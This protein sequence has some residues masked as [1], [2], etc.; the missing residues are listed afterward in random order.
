MV[1][2]KKIAEESGFSSATVSRLL[3]NDPT[4]SITEDTRKKILRTAVSLGYER[5]K[6]HISMDKIALLYW[7]SDKEELEDVYFR[8]MRLSIK[9]YAQLNNMDV[10][11]IKHH[12]GIEKVPKDISGFIAIGAFSTKE[13]ADLSEICPNGV[14]LDTNPDPDFF[15]SVQ[16]DTNR[17]TRKAIDYFISNNHKKIGFIGGTYLNPDTRKSEMDSREIV[18]RKYLEEKK[19][20]NEK[21]IFGEKH[22]SVKDGYEIANHLI[23]SLKKD[24][25]T[26]IFIASDPIAVGALQAFNEH[27]IPIPEQIEIISVNNIDVAKYVS[28]PLSS[29]AIDLDEM[30]KTAIDLLA[31]LIITGRKSR[32]QVYLNSKLVVRKS[33]Q[34][35]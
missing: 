20:L 28:P 13:I 25:P 24:L 35:K 17:I 16:P 21:Y 33:F 11:L 4:L 22:F 18:F 27:N 32:K 29:F 5:T 8:Q 30:S 12:H 34:P 3:K 2:I 15:D 19:L 7:I 14:F 26:A 1:T 23:S 10:E 31:D 9:K 6:I